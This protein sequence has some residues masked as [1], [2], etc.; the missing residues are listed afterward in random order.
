MD[1]PEDDDRQSTPQAAF[2]KAEPLELD[3]GAVYLGQVCGPLK[4]KVT[5]SNLHDVSL[6][7]S[8]FSIIYFEGGAQEVNDLSGYTKNPSD[9]NAPAECNIYFRPDRLG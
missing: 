3:F 7:S 8:L 5:S 2:L 1:L 6:S 9:K 4:I